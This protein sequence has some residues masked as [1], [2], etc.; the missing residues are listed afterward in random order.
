M[1]QD[2][3]N[4]VFHEMVQTFRYIVLPRGL[5][6]IGPGWNVKECVTL[7]TVP[8]FGEV[9]RISSIHMIPC[10]LTGIG[11][12]RDGKESV[13]SNTDQVFCENVRTFPLTSS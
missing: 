10:S 8:V 1:L 12:V 5:K 13:A 4:G 3:C 2:Y 7:D 6:R 11:P 9:S